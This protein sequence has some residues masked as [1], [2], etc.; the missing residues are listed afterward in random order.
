[1]ALE[2]KSIYQ[3]FPLFF[4]L[5]PN[6]FQAIYDLPP[7]AGFGYRMKERSAIQCSN[8]IFKLSHK[9]IAK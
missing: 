1:M 3:V 5:T 8:N 9:T 4:S 6:P 2:I 7:S